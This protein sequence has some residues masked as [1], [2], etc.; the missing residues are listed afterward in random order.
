[1]GAF[2]V[3]LFMVILVLTAGLM[4]VV[5]LMQK[6]SA[7]AGMGA[8]LGGGAAES[9]FGGE[10]ANVLLKYTI[11]IGVAFFVLSF[12]LY[13]GIVARSRPVASSIV[14]PGGSLLETKPAVGSTGNATT[15]L[16]PVGATSPAATDKS[17][18]PAAATTP[19]SAASTTTPSA[20]APATTTAPA[21][22]PAPADTTAPAPLPTP[23]P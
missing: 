10:T 23:A 19:T 6:P 5:I 14:V 15:G 3:T 16:P 4:T 20:V 18:A 22:T 8:A 17:T 13:L 2:L 7:N 1:M 11:W 21:T 12:G 9:I